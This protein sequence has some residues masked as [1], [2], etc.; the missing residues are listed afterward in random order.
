[1]SSAPLKLS[2]TQLPR[3]TFTAENLPGLIRDG[4]DLVRSIPSDSGTTRE[5]STL[6]LK[7]Q[8]AKSDADIKVLSSTYEGERWT[9]RV[10]NAEVPYDLIRKSLCEGKLESE[11][12]YLAKP[13]DTMETLSTEAF[14]DVKI[15]LEGKIVL[16]TSVTFFLCLSVWVK[17]ISSGADVHKLLHVQA[18]SAREFLQTNISHDLLPLSSGLRQFIVI[19]MPLTGQA[20]SESAVLGRYVSVDYVHELENGGAEVFLTLCVSVAPS[21]P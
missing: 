17:R 11:K 4:L 6:S 9:T 12:E 1:M 19:S 13:G 20:R 3:S 10:T 18:F 14:D 15:Q 8:L 2:L 21:A 7:W 16:L 5:P